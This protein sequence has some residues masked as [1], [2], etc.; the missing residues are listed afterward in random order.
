M[1]KIE[2]KPIFALKAALFSLVVHFYVMHTA[3][4]EDEGM[5]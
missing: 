2:D 5:A 3:S 1:I 4:D